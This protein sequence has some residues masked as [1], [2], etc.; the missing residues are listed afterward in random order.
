M[1]HYLTF[2]MCEVIKKKKWKSV[3]VADKDQEMLLK[4]QKKGHNWTSS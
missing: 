1:C 4:A 2:I 3:P